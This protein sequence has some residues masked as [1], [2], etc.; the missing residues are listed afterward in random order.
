VLMRGFDDRGFCFF[1]N[2]ESRKGRELAENPR[3]GAVWHW[4]ELRRQVRA[5]G[6]VERVGDDESDAY[7]Y[8]R[9]VASRFS[10][11]ASAQSR[12]VDGRAALEAAAAAEEA[13]FAG[14][15]PADVDR[16]LHWGGFRL[17]PVEVEFWLHRD[18]RLHDRV[19]YGRPAPG[20]PWT[21]RRLQP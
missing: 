8:R 4:P 20:E 6:A 17:V 14:S 13:R 12:A 15:D 5:V 10:A 16:P 7:W 19:V 3:A 21:I 11:R 9:P 18:D 1:T 2:Y